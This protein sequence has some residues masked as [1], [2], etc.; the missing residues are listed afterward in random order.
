MSKKKPHSQRSGGS[1]A[2]VAVAPAAKEAPPSANGAVVQGLVSSRRP[3]R[4]WLEVMLVKLSRWLGSLQVAVVSLS[5]FALVLAI[6]T[7][8]ESWYSDKLA[9]DLVYRAWWFNLLL[10]VL[11]L[12][13][14]FAA[15]KKWPWKKHQTGFLITHVGLLLL[16]TGGLLTGLGGTDTTMALVDVPDPSLRAEVSQLYAADMP[17][18]SSQVSDR[19]YAVIHV[20]RIKGGGKDLAFP[21]QSASLFWGSHDHFHPSVDPLLKILDVLAHPWP[22][23]WQADVGGGATLEVLASYPHVSRERFRPAETDEKTTFPAVQYSLMSPMAPEPQ[24]GWVAGNGRNSFGS[25]GGVALVHLLGNV[26]TDL[27]DEFRN[28]PTAQV[29]GKKGVLIVRWDGQT[30]RL[31]VEQALGQSAT[32]LGTSGWKVRVLDYQPNFEQDAREREASN[33]AVKFEVAGPGGA[34]AQFDVLG[35]MP[36]IAFPHDEKPLTGELRDLSKLQVWYHPPDQ[37]FGQE[38]RALLQV[39]IGQG[40]QLYFRSFNSSKGEFAF[41]K[42]GLATKGDEQSIWGGMNWKFKVEE[43]LPRAV[44]EPWFK[45]LSLRPGLEDKGGQIKAAVRCRLHQGKD[46]KDFW[47][48]RTEK[49]TTRVTVA[50]EEFEI[51]YNDAIS[52]LGFEIKLLRAEE[53]VDPGTTTAASYTSYVQLTDPQEG[54]QAADRVVTM[55]QPLEHRGYKFFQIG[56]NPIRWDMLSRPPAD[57]KPINVSVFTVSRDPG[58]WLKYLGSTMLALGIAC[59]FYMKAYFFKPRGQRSAGSAPAPA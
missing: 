25:V 18:S 54:I 24:Q 46:A 32:A 55:N 40:E 13:I 16:V 44:G 43:Y 8:V 14:F 21:F 1:S 53:Y 39:G 4:F 11:G 17:Q 50:G 42:A 10:F 12:N 38:I 58:L 49:S 20:K 9:K 51:G 33:P 6:G 45:P 41:E 29:A 5:L 31:P 47:V 48:G 15:V 59:M 28:P 37:R 34:S 56:L 19:E 30:V 57:L 27:L 52:D 22:R 26:P 23:S 35:R 3:E 7:C 36:S 2:S